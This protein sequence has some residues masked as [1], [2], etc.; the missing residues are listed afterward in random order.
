MTPELLYLEMGRHLLEDQ[1][2]SR[3]LGMVYDHPLFRQCPF[4]MLRRLRQTE[5]SPLYHPEGNV[6]NHTL[7]VVDEAA[8]VR[9]RSADPAAFM[10]AA[11]L[12]DVGKPASTR[13]RNGRITH[14]DHDKAGAVLARVFLLEFTDDRAFIDRVCALVRYHMHVL[15]VVKG[16]PFADLPGMKRSVD[17]GEVALLGLCDR[18]GRTAFDAEKEQRDI[19]FFL[20]KT[21]L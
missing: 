11:L 12:H 20:R 2:P 6:W 14:Y 19:E 16:L 21:R 10:W 15:Y 4:D 17:S 9:G 18:M 13:I 7:L 8:K 3:Y 1:K 5:Q